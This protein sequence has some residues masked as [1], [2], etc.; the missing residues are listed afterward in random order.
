[1]PEK[2]GIALARMTG[3]AATLAGAAVF[4]DPA[5][6]AAKAWYPA[7]GQTIEIDGA[8]VHSTDRRPALRALARE[9]CRFAP[10]R[11]RAR[12]KA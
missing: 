9:R 7:I 2:Q 6:C 8:R 12:F 5:A 10:H 11:R 3:G 4:N 1:M